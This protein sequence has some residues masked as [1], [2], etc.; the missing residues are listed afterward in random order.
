MVSALDCRSCATLPVHG[1]AHRYRRMRGERRLLG[2]PGRRLWCVVDGR[3]GGRS[4]FR[5]WV[6][7]LHTQALDSGNA[8]LGAVDQ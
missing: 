4:L 2:E 7:A 3:R 8:D 1:V 6:G 5:R